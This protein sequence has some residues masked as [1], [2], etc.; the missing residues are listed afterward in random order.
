[1]HSPLRTFA[2]LLLLVAVFFT[3]ARSYAQEVRRSI[4]VVDVERQPT[5]N[6]NIT[7]TLG[8]QRLEG[9]TDQLGEWQFVVADHVGSHRAQISVVGA[10]Y[11]P[12]DTLIDLTSDVEHVVKLR[13][14]KHKEAS[15]VGFRQI[16]SANAEKTVFKINT[17]SLLPT[18]KAPLEL[19]QVPGLVATGDGI[20]LVG[21]SK[22]VKIKVNGLEISEEELAKLDAKDIN[23]VEV[24]EFGLPDDNFAGEVNLI[25]K[26]TAT[27]FYK[28]EVY[29]GTDFNRLSGGLSPSFT[30]RG[31]K[32]DLFALGNLAGSKQTSTFEMVRDQANYFSSRSESDLGQYTILARGNLIFSPRWLTSLSYANFGYQTPAKM[33]WW[34]MGQEQQL[35]ELNERVR[36]HHGNVVVRYDVDAGRRLYLK[37][38]YFNYHSSHSSTQPTQHNLSQMKEWT[39]ETL[40]EIDQFSLF[41]TK[42]AMTLG[43]KGIFRNSVLEPSQMR[44]TNDVLQLYLKD[45][46]AFARQWSVLLL[47]RSE[48]DG[49]QLPVARLQRQWAFLPSATLHYQGTKGRVAASYA[50]SIER[51][52]VDYL[53]PSLLQTNGLDQMQGNIHLVPQYTN[54]W[55]LA[56]NH[57]VKDHYFSVSAYAAH[58]H[59]LLGLF[60]FNSLNHS[61]YENIGQV[62]RS[63]MRVGYNKAVFGSRLH[64]NLNLGADHHDINAR[65]A[66]QSTVQRMRNS[67]WAWVSNANVTY[68]TSSNW[69]FNL[70]MAYVSKRLSFGTTTYQNPRLDLS[71]TKTLLGDKMELSLNYYDMFGWY[72]RQRIDYNFQQLQQSVKS[73]SPVSLISFGVTYRF[74]HKFRAR[75]IGT[76]ISNDDITTKS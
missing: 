48:W 39:A 29:A 46:F 36:N 75:S 51:P 47:L 64:L 71:I 43:V 68:T 21:Q 53:N 2:Q 35:R 31:D 63:G 49:V 30:Y 26:K 22:R 14:L 44:Y 32:M 13:P 33:N 12:L 66:L 18:T 6:V 40:G 55:T 8:D 34:L 65:P 60:Y 62:R 5:P 19:R 56:Y 45:H 54:R 4:I 11:E 41:G 23:R 69:L 1:M 42:H 27:H 25:L 3:A 74:G 59:N 70:N 16:A 52:N 72:S 7:L 50:R 17:K 28:G 67:G 9:R 24:R 57:Q 61:T 76:S 58:T 38:R 20:K 37:G 10:L 15:V 73:L